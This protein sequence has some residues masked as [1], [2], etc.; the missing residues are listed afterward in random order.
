VSIALAV[1]AAYMAVASAQGA[2]A[3]AWDLAQL[4]QQRAQ[5]TQARAR[6]T[7]QR[8]SDLF[9]RPFILSGTLR[10]DSPARVEK[11]IDVPFKERYVV[12]GDVLRIEYAGK[13]PRTVSLREHP[14]LWA[15]VESFRATLAGDLS[16]LQR[17]YE[18][19]LEGSREHWRLLLRPRNERMRELV[20]SIKMEGSD[21]DITA[22]EILEV[23]GD[24]SRLSI[25]PAPS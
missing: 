6:F 12:D 19:S 22:I 14:A 17:F 10:Y 2:D 7:E 3:R 13:R 25:G 5:V 15:F 9:D 23:G 21:A 16:T 18:V 8:R 1:A 11:Q 20:E 24:S 4:M